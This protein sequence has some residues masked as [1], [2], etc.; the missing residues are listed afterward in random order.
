M[1]ARIVRRAEGWLPSGNLGQQ[2]HPLSH[3]GLKGAGERRVRATM[4]RQDLAQSEELREDGILET[5]VMAPKAP[6]VVH[7]TVEGC[8]GEREHPPHERFV[9]DR[10]VVRNGQETLTTRLVVRPRLQ[11]VKE[12]RQAMDLGL[13][14]AIE[15][16]TREGS[17]GQDRLV[18]GRPPE[19]AG[20]FGVGIEVAVIAERVHWACRR[21]G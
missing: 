19:K 20:G 8:E 17:N 12:P 4:R 6:S 15:E 16:Q 10:D 13:V 21:R 1:E 14:E 5:D 2:P 3:G 9:H 18:G 11:Q 7:V